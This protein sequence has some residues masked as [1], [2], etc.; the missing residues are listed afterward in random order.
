MNSSL[1]VARCGPRARRPIVNRPPTCG[2]ASPCGPLLRVASRASR[3]SKRPRQIKRRLPALSRN[4]TG[5]SLQLG[6]QIE[7]QGGSS[8]RGNTGQL[9]HGGERVAASLERGLG[10]EEAPVQ[11]AEEGDDVHGGVAIGDVRRD[12]RGAACT[13]SYDWSRRHRATSLVWPSFVGKVA[14]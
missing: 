3:T 5:G 1:S 9:G 10:E 12:L 14:A 6:D 2:A 4:V 13:A 7:A 11:R 8:S